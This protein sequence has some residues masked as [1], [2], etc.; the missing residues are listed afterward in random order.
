MTTENKPTMTNEAVREFANGLAGWIQ[1]SA[2]AHENSFDKEACEA[3]RIAKD[4][5]FEAAKE[6]GEPHAYLYGIFD[7]EQFYRMTL[8][9]AVQSV[10]P[11]DM[12]EPVYY[13]LRHTWNDMQHWCETIQTTAAKPE[14]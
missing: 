8:L 10:T 12:V 14:A 13:L 7:A 9:Q 2:A 6:A 5:E 4:A 11:A 3:M 1:A